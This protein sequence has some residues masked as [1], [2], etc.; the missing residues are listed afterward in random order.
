MSRLTI[1]ACLLVSGLTA[2]VYQLVWTRLLGLSFGTTTE[3]I[4]TVLAVFSGGLALG[5]WLAARLLVRLARPLRAYAALE[6]GIGL[7]A[8]V[9]LPLLWNLD[10]L[11]DLVGA[12]ESRL[13]LG[14]LRFAAAA[15]LL[16]PPTLAMGATLPVVAR[17]LVTRDEALGRWSAWLYGANTV[18]AVLGAYLC[19]FWSIPLLGLTR[20]L[21]AAGCT[22]LLVGALAAWAARGAT[23]LA[24]PPPDPPRAADEPSRRAFLFYFAISGFVAIGYE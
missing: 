2:L 17:A 11:H 9:T 10:A 21:V 12:P 14:V 4:A 20:T 22:N 6:A 3:A 7:Y 15:L 18:G 23:P 24:P 1:I 13:A 19:G 8:L 5:N 16:L